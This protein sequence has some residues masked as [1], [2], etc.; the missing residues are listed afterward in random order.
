MLGRPL[1]QSRGHGEPDLKNR[2]ISVAEDNAFAAPHTSRVMTVDLATDD[3]EED[4]L[5]ELLKSDD[6]E[7]QKD[8]KFVVT[9]MI[10]REAVYLSSSEEDTPSLTSSETEADDALDKESFVLDRDSMTQ[11]LNEVVPP[12]DTTVKGSNSSEPDSQ[13][14]SSTSQLIS[15]R[16]NDDF[17]FGNAEDHNENHVDTSREIQIDNSRTENLFNNTV[18]GRAKSTTA[19]LT[20]WRTPVPRDVSEDSLYTVPKKQSNHSSPDDEASNQL[21]A[22]SDQENSVRLPIG[23]GTDDSNYS[24]DS[25]V[26]IVDVRPVPPKISVQR[27]N[28]LIERY[29]Y[30][31]LLKK[32]SEEYLRTLRNE[33]RKMKRFIEAMNDG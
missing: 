3:E 12:Q 1:V 19:T 20:P 18:A 16:N 26:E 15:S 13:F 2:K 27:L 22:I 6:L 9:P 8:N 24:S 21:L 33:I 17:G 30:K 14:E 4:D 11:D 32:S 29:R 5:N 25:D 28:E 31:E 7:D 23:G 10:E